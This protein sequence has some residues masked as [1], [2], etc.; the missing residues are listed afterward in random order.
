MNFW[1]RA[2][3]VHVIARLTSVSMSQRS[4]PNNFARP[5]PLAAI[6]LLHK[7]SETHTNERARA[8]VYRVRETVQMRAEPI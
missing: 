1:M 7:R 5:C 3:G 6:A 4:S 2:Y 8:R